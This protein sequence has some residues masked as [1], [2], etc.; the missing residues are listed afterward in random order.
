MSE[1]GF[2]DIDIITN[3][4]TSSL[5]AKEELKKLVMLLM[6]QIYFGSDS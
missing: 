6:R 3:S 1:I 2:V 5:T 4:R